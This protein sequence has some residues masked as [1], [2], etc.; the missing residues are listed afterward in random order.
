MLRVLTSDMITNHLISLINSQNVE[1]L[2]C[3]LFA[4]NFINYLDRGIIPGA[5]N[6]FDEFISDRLHTNTPDVY[7]GMLQS[8]FIVGF[9][10]ASLVFGR[11]V[12]FYGPF[13]L[14]GIGL[15]IWTTAVICS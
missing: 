11:L 13:F 1:F 9:C 4:I 12:H 7:L 2:F 6:E 14:C 10:L 3:V 5:T 8:S 15:S